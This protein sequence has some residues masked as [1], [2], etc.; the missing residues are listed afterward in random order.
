MDSASVTRF[1]GN[2]SG[3][4]L[5]V[6]GR[7][8]HPSQL[9]T[10]YKSVTRVI[11]IGRKSS[12]AAD[13]PHEDP[14][15]YGRALFR[16]PVVSRKHA[17]ITFTEFGNAYIIDLH[18]HHG[19]H[20]LRPG[21]SMSRM[22]K[23]EVPTVLADG[24]MVTFGKTV[25]RDEH[26]VRPVT[27]HVKLLFG[28]D[29]APT[30]SPSLHSIAPLE[31]S[32]RAATKAGSGRYGV[33][34]F[35]DSSLS[36]SDEDSDSDMESPPSLPA[37][38]PAI[39]R[40]SMAV[41]SAG[42]SSRLHFLRQFLP[43]LHPLYADLSVQVEGTDEEDDSEVSSQSSES[44]SISSVHEYSA[45]EPSV[46]GAWPG[47]PSGSVSPL[48]G[49]PLSPHLPPTG[50]SSEIYTFHDK[51]VNQMSQ[52][53]E[54][55]K[56]SD[57]LG[58]HDESSA[59]SNAVPLQTLPPP[60][61]V[62]QEESQRAPTDMRED[63]DV[64]IITRGSSVVCS[65]TDGRTSEPEQPHVVPYQGLST[66]YETESPHVP[67]YHEPYSE[68]PIS[69]AE[70]V[71][72]AEV[73]ST[74][75]GRI[76]S[77]SNE[78]TMLRILRR[79]DELRFDDHI[80]ETKHRLVDLDQRMLDM[81]CRLSSSSAVNDVDLSIAR[82]R[83][84]DLQTHIAQ[85]Q[86][87][88]L[89]ST[90]ADDRVVVNEDVSGDVQSAKAMLEELR[91]FRENAEQQIAKELEGIR[92]ARLEAEAA[93][94][95]ALASVEATSQPPKR[96]RPDYEDDNTPADSTSSDIVVNPPKR[97]RTMTAA[98]KIVQT[99]TIATIGAMAAWTA[100]AFS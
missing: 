71:R 76:N 17:K 30:P 25:G 100:L 87:Q 53:E 63:D 24:D 55:P 37:T 80:Q 11:S 13:G 95:Q 18:S 61:P 81:T 4:T 10:Y 56:L 16:C 72:Q 47:S 29:P 20:I 79:Q 45:D 98:T 99:A 83:L 88:S 54:V 26:L 60:P 85:L 23:S 74:I 94:A 44:T 2:I 97:R 68:S 66:S 59:E 46:V 48:S 51:L 73:L 35:S 92:A 3:I 34:L 8:G 96:K 89:L 38:L 31:S 12:Q 52:N 90:P 69:V 62:L 57:E 28:S 91:L 93:S 39:R 86:T 75:E 33:T 42:S 67:T 19:T 49:V 21:D 1:A 15:E 58:Q 64:V 70:E 7:D 41:A 65:F 6:D 32:E 43:P 36:T 14:Y 77:V 22:I 40:A 78:I 5:H 82:S 9:L 27:V 50:L 84:D